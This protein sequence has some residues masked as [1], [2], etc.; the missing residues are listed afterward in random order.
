[1]G[2]KALARQKKRERAAAEAA[3][4]TV[5]DVN[6][7]L[8]AE[9]SAAPELPA[10]APAPGIDSTKIATQL[11]SVA[12]HLLRRLHRED[13]ALGLSGARL[14]ALSV[15]VFG[16]PRTIGKLAE[17]EGVTPPSMTR[18]VAAME[19]EGLVQRAP[20][21][22]D[23]RAVI[24]RATAQGEEIMLRGREQRVVAL[25]GWLSSLDRDE[26]NTLEHAAE[27]LERILSEQTSGRRQAT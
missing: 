2:T 21:S 6:E 26:L 18:L 11:N 8:P 22:T 24:I 27:L 16:G 7:A 20:S 4:T 19:T 25:T 9:A 12:I 10:N 5:I 17:A 14:S 13:A 15:L 23:A 1:M 3:I